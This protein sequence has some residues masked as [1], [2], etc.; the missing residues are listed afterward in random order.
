MIELYLLLKWTQYIRILQVGG[1][2]EGTKKGNYG[3]L[4]ALCK[5]QR[6]DERIPGLAKVTTGIVMIKNLLKGF[7]AAI[8][9]IWCCQLNV[10]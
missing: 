9:H 1:V 4:L 5:A 10:P 7:K 8:V 6:F 2:G 3:R